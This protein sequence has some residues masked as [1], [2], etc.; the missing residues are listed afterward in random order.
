MRRRRGFDGKETFFV[1]VGFKVST[2]CAIFHVCV[3]V[4]A[5]PG[6]CT[7]ASLGAGGS[8]GVASLSR[9]CEH[10]DEAECEH[11]DEEED[12]VRRVQEISLACSLLATHSGQLCFPFSFSF[13][14]SLR[15]STHTWVP[16]PLY[17]S[18]P[19]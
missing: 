9:A 3:C 13:P 8:S 15:P 17:P 4:C 5:S 1:A 18:H 19:P 6:E 16:P 11:I 7:F 2:E 12:V 10:I 14:P